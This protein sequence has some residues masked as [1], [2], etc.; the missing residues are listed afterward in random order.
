MHGLPL[1]PEG[2][3]RSLSGA[4]TCVTQLSCISCIAKLRYSRKR[5]RRC[6]RGTQLSC[7]SQLREFSSGLPEAFPAGTRDAPRGR[8]ALSREGEPGRNG[9]RHRVSLTRQNPGLRTGIPEFYLSL[10][11]SEDGKRRKGPYSTARDGQRRSAPASIRKR[12]LNSLVFHT[13]LNSRT[14]VKRPPNA[15]Q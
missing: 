6:L 11:P 9:Q 15:L 1:L 14:Q 5:L 13:S 3:G 4:V 7:I 8:A 2:D 10:A 12:Q